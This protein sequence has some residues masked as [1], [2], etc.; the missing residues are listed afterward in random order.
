MVAPFIK[1]LQPQGGTF[2]TFSSSSED[3]GMTFNNSST[4]FRFSKYLLLNLPNIATPSFSDNKIQFSSIDGALIEGLD[5]D[6]NINLAQSFQNY[7]LNFE[8]LLVSQ[9]TYD[10][11]LKQNVAERVFWKWLKEIGCIRFEKANSL[12]S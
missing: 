9:I 7:A 1:T 11:Y 6:N 5:A 3:V 10:R 12:Q 2:Y 4:K 8:S